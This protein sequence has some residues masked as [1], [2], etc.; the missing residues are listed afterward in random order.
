M[1]ILDVVIIGLAGW[2]LASLLVTEE[3]P[4]LIFMRFRMWLGVREEPGEQ[5][6]GFFPLVFSCM[7]CMSVWTTLLAAGIWYL[8]P[9]AVM[10]VAA[11]AVALIPEALYGGSPHRN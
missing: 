2:R 8:E 4:G 9:V 10:I 3:G 5:S 11:M 1:N 6:S 7:W